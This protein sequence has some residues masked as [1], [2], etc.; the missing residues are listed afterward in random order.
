MN[1]ESWWSIGPRAIAWWALRTQVATLRIEGLER[2]PAAGPVLLVAR[3]YHHLLDGAV[4]VQHVPRPVHIVVALD[5]AADML[6]RRGM[7]F[8]CRLARYPIFLRAA[9]LGERRGYARSELLRTTRGGVRE[10]TALLREG[11]VV[12]VFP[13]GY[14]NVDPAFT[15]KT[16][17]AFLPFEPGYLRLVVLA[18]R[19]GATRVAVVPVGFHY[20]QGETEAGAT[21]TAVRNWTIVARIGAASFDPENDAVE[22]AVHALSRPD[23]EIGPSRSET[24]RFGHP[25][26]EV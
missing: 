24:N 2:I 12:L 25:M 8:A 19:D 20:E 6:Q 1:P 15:R 17:D 4:L 13:E 22:R 26:G 16:G 7:E 5:W 3:H 23:A 11:R 14:P 21:A 10:T 9:T 18:Q